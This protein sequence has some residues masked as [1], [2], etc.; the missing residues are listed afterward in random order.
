M[1]GTSLLKFRHFFVQIFVI[2]R[3][4]HFALDKRIEI[5]EIRDHPVA[6]STGPV[7]VT[8]SDV[9]VPVPVGIVALAVDALIFCLAETRRD[10]ADARPQSGSAASA[11]A[12][13][14]VLTRR[15]PF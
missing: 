1:V 4:D 3:L 15:L 10:A 8:S 9:V 13:A 6:G 2:E 7:T 11:K 5:A 14:L 12:S